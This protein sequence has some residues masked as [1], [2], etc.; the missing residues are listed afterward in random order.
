MPSC[1]HSS[2]CTTDAH[3]LVT[4]NMHRGSKLASWYHNSR[5]TRY[6]TCVPRR[7]SKPNTLIHIGW[8]R[9]IPKYLLLFH[10]R[11]SSCQLWQLRGVS[12]RFNIR[13]P[14]SRGHKIKLPEHPVLWTRPCSELVDL[15]RSRVL[16]TGQENIVKI[17]S[18]LSRVILFSDRPKHADIRRRFGIG[19]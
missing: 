7:Q 2:W 12:N 5:N 14:A 16:Q 1:A 8:R 13:W 19:T 11:G 15:F 4:L 17:Y 3:P 9:S 10:T 18:Q 6:S